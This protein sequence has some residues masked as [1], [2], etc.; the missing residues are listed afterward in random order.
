V[1]RSVGVISDPFWEAVEGEL[2]RLAE[3]CIK[4]DGLV[5]L[6]MADYTG[7]NQEILAERGGFEPPIELLTL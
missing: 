7:E 4:M 1:L 6:P 5:G 2:H 3:N